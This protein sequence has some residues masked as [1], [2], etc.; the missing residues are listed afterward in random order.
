MKV[1]IYLETDRYSQAQEK[2]KYGYVIE[3]VIK[4]QAITREGFGQ[5]EG[6]LHNV[7]LRALAEAMERFRS[8]CEVCV[9]TKDVFVASRIRRLREMAAAG[10]L[11]K[12]GIKIKNADEWEQIHRKAEECGI[13]FSGETGKHQYSGWMEEEMSKNGFKGTAGESVEPEI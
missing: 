8:E 5:A 4:D 12:K 13:V 9:H 7:I 3:T 2:R 11:D 1:N 10:F 6:T